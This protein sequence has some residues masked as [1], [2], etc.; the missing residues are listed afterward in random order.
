[1]ALWCWLWSFAFLN[2]QNPG[3]NEKDWPS[4]SSPEVEKLSDCLGSGEPRAC[5]EE[6][7]ALGNKAYLE[8]D[9]ALIINYLYFKASYLNRMNRFGEAIA[10]QK[11]AEAMGPKHD[12]LAYFKIL[13]SLGATYFESQD[14]YKSIDYLI[15][16][17]DIHDAR[18]PAFDRAVLMNYLGILYY[19]EGAYQSAWEY[20]TKA[21]YLMHKNEASI[22]AARKSSWLQN[23]LSN[24][25]L[26]HLRLGRPELAL[27]FFNIA[28]SEAKANWN[29]DG[30]GLAML[31]KGRAIHALHPD[32]TGLYYYEKAYGLLLVN[33]S[34]ELLANTVSLL[35]E[36]H[37]DLGQLSG[38]A[39]YVVM[40]LQSLNNNRSLTS[41]QAV[42]SALARYHF[43]TGAYRPASEYYQKA[44]LLLD[45]LAQLD[46]KNL[47]QL[48]A[49][50]QKLSQERAERKLFEAQTESTNENYRTTIVFL[51]IAGAILLVLGVLLNRL[52]MQQRRTSRLLSTVRM[53]KEALEQLNAELNL[54]HVH[55]NYLLGAVAHDIRNLLGNVNQV[56]ELLLM[57]FEGEDEQ[58]RRSKHLL[59]LMNQSGR[60]GMHTIQDLLEGVRPEGEIDLEKEPLMPEN[61][62]QEVVDLL[63]L[64]AERKQV[65]IHT[66]IE[67]N[68]SFLADPDKLKR[69]LLNVLDNAIKFSPSRAEIHLWVEKEDDFLSIKVQDQGV[70]FK[71]SSKPNYKEPFSVEGRKGTA[72]ET[73][74]GLGLYIVH[75]LISAH[76]GSLSIDNRPEGG[77][78]VKLRIPM[79]D[80]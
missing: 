74:T 11:E 47:M 8:K 27:K 50:R 29:T 64:R 57:D 22:Q 68:R 48:E 28:Y 18:I 6:L 43:L 54:T 49:T 20:F 10:V 30:M 16:A 25:G 21:L 56:S 38:A 7:E 59:H 77:A 44:N 39:P 79:G 36:A 31:N 71:D 45:S 70:G 3:M 24:I 62:V 60:L 35:M 72:G 4:V 76:G 63:S 40:A 13:I 58:S 33:R 73:T 52:Y 75:K 9:S 26:C 19:Q 61:L 51:I 15:R 46:S 37:M 41:V 65:P 32:S 23:V 42:Y 55:K 53:Q 14:Y 17:E 5:L 2:A 1:M 69:A 12:G 78:E 80:R 67:F 66:H 34:P